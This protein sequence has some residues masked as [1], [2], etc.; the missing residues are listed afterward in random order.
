MNTFIRLRFPT[1][2]LATFFSLMEMQGSTADATITRVLPP[3]G[4]KI[5]DADR[6]KL[7]KSL[8]DFERELADVKKKSNDVLANVLPDAEIYYKAARLALDLDEFAKPEQAAEALK[9][10]QTGRDRLKEIV[11]SK[12]K[13]SWSS[14]HGLVVRGY[15]SKLDDSVQPYGLLI[16]D[17]L[18][19]NKPSPLY[20]WLHGRNDKGTDLAFL[21]EQEKSKGQ[22]TP[23]D[24]MVLHVFGR[25][26]NAFKFAGEIDIFEA[27]ASVKSRYKIDDRKIILIG[28]SMGGAGCW[29][30]AA[31]YPGVW[32]AAC[33][34]AGFVDVKRYQNLSGDKLPPAIEQ[35]LWGWYDVPDYARNMFN[36]PVIAYSGEL[37]K[38]KASADIMEEVFKSHGQKLERII[39]PK[40]EHKYEPNA[41]KEIHKRLHDIAAKGLETNPPQV[42]LQ[43]KTLRYATSFW[44]TATGLDEHYRDARIDA[45]LDGATKITLTTTNVRELK[46][47]SPWGDKTNF[48]GVSISMDGQTLAANS[49]TGAT[50]SGVP[51]NKSAKQISL[52]KSADG[53]WGF[54]NDSADGL[55]KVPGLQGPIDDAFMERF[56]VVTPSGKSSH[57]KMQAFVEAEL[58]HFQRRWQEMF[59]G[60]VL[61]KK[62]TD[63][64][65][66]DLKNCNLIVW[67]DPESNQ[68]LAK[69]IKQLPLT[70][71]DKNVTMAGKSYAAETH[72]PAMIYPNPL[73][74]T[75]YIV[76]NSGITFREGHDKTNSLQT[77]K[78]P[79]WAVIDV[80]QPPDDKTPGKIVAADFFDEQWQVKK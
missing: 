30:L 47:N 71:D 63:V 24:A 65:S 3:P 31:H 67:G 66:D 25:Y 7:K 22:I 75:K 77:P 32:A 55:R 70:W 26:C 21:T 12:G 35:T 1:I 69:V 14:A 43:T 29:H 76:V 48:K 51:L 13:P 16:P 42:T 37:D 38:Q 68:F 39:G 80:T 19:L 8:A 41:L 61:L 36:Y 74:P 78:L 50:A 52:Q 64:T 27:M 34:G 23:D 40:V 11:T 49:A 72:V 53:R 5:A 20:V 15:R 6:E 59:R 57:P 9:H 4:V 54:A 28:F 45:K 33:P 62:D 79:D 18:D 2:L 44:V 46:L 10:L 17:K 56:L 58:A 60:Q 73:S